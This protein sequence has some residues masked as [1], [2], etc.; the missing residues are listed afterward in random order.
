MTL[1]GAGCNAWKPWLMPSAETVGSNDRIS[2][3]RLRC[4]MKSMVCAVQVMMMRRPVRVDVMA[5][6]LLRG[7]RSAKKV[8]SAESRVE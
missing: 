5:N 7:S 2:F 4:C 1:L 8:R 3:D 6:A